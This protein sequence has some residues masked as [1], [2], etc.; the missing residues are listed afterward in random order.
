MFLCRPKRSARFQ[1][2]TGYQASTFHSPPSLVFLTGQYKHAHVLQMSFQS[3]SI[4]CFGK[5]KCLMMRIEA[6]PSGNDVVSEEL[7]A[8]KKPQGKTDLPILWEVSHSYMGGWTDSC[9]NR[10]SHMQEPFCGTEAPRTLWVWELFR[11][12]PILLPSPTCAWTWVSKFN[13]YHTGAATRLL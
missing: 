7:L 6:I 5:S 13:S 10:H 1:S 12:K 11:V 2:R 9:W 3:N 4:L 8:P